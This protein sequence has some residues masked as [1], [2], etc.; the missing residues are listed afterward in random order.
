MECYTL[1]DVSFSYPECREKALDGVDLTVRQGD[2]LVL[3][4]ASG[5][6]EIHPAAAAQNRAV[7]PWYTDG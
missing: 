2:F 4:G 3:F 1:R 7:S 6:G 5:C